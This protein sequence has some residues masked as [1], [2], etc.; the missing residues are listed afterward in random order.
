MYFMSDF[1]KYFFVVFSI[2]SF[3][4]NGQAID[5]SVLSQL[6]PV[7]IEMAKDTYARSNSSD[8][9]IEELHQI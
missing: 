5:E 2:C 1:R 4:L 6:S 9:T 7:Q 3:N 8:L